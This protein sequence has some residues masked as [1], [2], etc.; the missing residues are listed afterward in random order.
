[1]MSKP[2]PRTKV[3]HK[4]SVC[5]KV[6]VRRDNLIGHMS[7]INKCGANED[8][9]KT[10]IAME[11]NDAL[12]DMCNHYKELNTEPPILLRVYVSDLRSKEAIRTLEEENKDLQQTVVSVT[13]KYTY[14]NNNFKKEIKTRV[15]AEIF[16]LQ[17]EVE[18]TNASLVTLCG[19][20]TRLYNRECIPKAYYIQPDELTTWNVKGLGNVTAEQFEKICDTN[21]Y[22]PS[23]VFHRCIDLI[24]GS[25]SPPMIAVTNINK[26]KFLIR[27]NDASKEESMGLLMILLKDV[28]EK[29]AKCIK[30]VQASIVQEYLIIRVPFNSTGLLGEMSMERFREIYDIEMG[31]HGGT[32]P[33]A[34]RLYEHHQKYSFLLTALQNVYLYERSPKFNQEVTMA[35]AGYVKSYLDVLYTTDMSVVHRCRRMHSDFTG[36]NKRYY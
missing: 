25:V 19:T 7:D 13:K 20:M 11:A 32:D 26:R 21:D 34:V 24:L 10:L 29:I 1:M 27:E 30:D 36:N 15:A 3:C 33:D 2:Q 4:C 23:V 28:S 35:L 9:V 5:N 17:Q 8:A 31:Y 16:D 18:D 14:L 22:M 12:F 6:Y